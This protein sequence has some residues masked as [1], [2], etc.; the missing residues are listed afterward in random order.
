MQCNHHDVNLI[1]DKQKK[2]QKRDRLRWHWQCV[3]V[4]IRFFLN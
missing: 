2:I 1:L 3:D 4:K